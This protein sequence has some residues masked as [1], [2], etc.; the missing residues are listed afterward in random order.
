MAL[1]CYEALKALGLRIPEDVSV[2]GYDDRE[3]AQHLHPALT[4][5][6]L[7]HF[8]MGAMAVELVLEQLAAASR[9][10][11]QLKAECPLVVRQSTGP[12][13]ARA[14]EHTGEKGGLP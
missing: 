6:V 12:T 5:V 14:A 9:P 1:G 8:V 2:V 10:P 3:I 13:R 4:T 7:P 11:L